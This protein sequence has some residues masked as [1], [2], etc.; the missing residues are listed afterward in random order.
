M[1]QP[2]DRTRSEHSLLEWINAMNPI[3]ISVILMALIGVGWWLYARG[4]D[5]ERTNQMERTLQN[6]DTFNKGADNPDGGSWFDR[7]FPDA[8]D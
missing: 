5:N 6:A 2:D 3:F 4:A 1:R 7:L 8:T